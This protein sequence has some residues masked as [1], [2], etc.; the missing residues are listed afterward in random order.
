MNDT[1]SAAE[2]TAAGA[3]AGAEDPAAPVSRWA[4]HRRLYDWVL[5][6]AHHRYGTSALFLISFAESSF[7][8]I[9]PDVLL[10]PMCLGHRRRAIWFATVTTVASVLG[11]L[12]GYLI[13]YG[14]IEWALMIP[15]ITQ[16]RINWLA[17]EFDVLGQWYVF[18]AAL[19]PIPFKL[20][21]ITSGFAT[22]NLI[23]F[24]IACV[25]GRAARFFA[26][27]ILIWLIGPK[28]MPL[29]DRYFNLLCVVF[30]I[31]LIGGFAVIKL[32]H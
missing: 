1:Q 14:A 11:A 2:V 30:M 18:I 28:V 9:P 12:L 29:I 13:G 21:T 17:G 3:A 32:M 16:E 19:T 5:G 27:A 20:L 15:G 24:V 25:I 31:L 7:F 8:P 10:A 4:I 26:V 22:M 6:F 23:V